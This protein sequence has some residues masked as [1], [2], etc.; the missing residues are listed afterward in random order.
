V[1][2]VTLSCGC[3]DAVIG[4][5]DSALL[6]RSRNGVILFDERARRIKWHG[7]LGGCT[8]RGRLGIAIDMPSSRRRK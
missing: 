8:P 5:G 6:A 1:G 7:A 3:A 2:D 4:A